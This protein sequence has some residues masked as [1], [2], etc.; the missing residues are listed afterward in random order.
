[1]KHEICN[2][3]EI[4]ALRATLTDQRN[5]FRQDSQA[6]LQATVEE[7]IRQLKASAE[8]HAQQT[9]AGA[10]MLREGAEQAADTLRQIGEQSAVLERVVCDQNG[11][12]RF[13][14][15]CGAMTVEVTERY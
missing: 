15:R 9:P 1:M 5:A 7:Q 2:G 12:S 10:Q 3:C 11:P 14:G 4:G 8:V 6:D 13:L